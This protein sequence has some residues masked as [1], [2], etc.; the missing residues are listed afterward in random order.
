M[1]R[2]NGRSLQFRYSGFQAARH[3]TLKEMAAKMKLSQHF[4]FDLVLE[5][6]SKPRILHWHGYRTCYSGNTIL[7][8]VQNFKVLY[9]HSYRTCPFRNTVLTLLWN[10]S[11]RKYCIHTVTDAVHLRSRTPICPTWKYIWHYTG[12]VLLL[13]KIISLLWECPS[14]LEK[15]RH[16]PVMCL[17]LSILPSR[18]T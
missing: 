9:Q 7:P 6:S 18:R 14:T 13:Q 15:N 4:F 8:Q 2:S 17:H 11:H 5:L 12:S 10:L 16:K 3:T 1:L